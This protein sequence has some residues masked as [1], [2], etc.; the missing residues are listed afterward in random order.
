MK[1]REL[2]TSHYAKDNFNGIKFS[3][4]IFF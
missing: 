2:I 4:V 3:A 1:I